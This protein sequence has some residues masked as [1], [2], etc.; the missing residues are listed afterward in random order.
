LHALAGA[1]M[2]VRSPT[3]QTETGQVTTGATID[4][5]PGE[6]QTAVTFRSGDWGCDILTA[7]RPNPRVTFAAHDRSEVVRFKF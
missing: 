1:E 3:H 6:P 4:A 2:R 7:F 5:G